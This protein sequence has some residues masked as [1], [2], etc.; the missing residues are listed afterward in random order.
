MSIGPSVNCS[1]VSQPGAR[2]CSS[3][4]ICN[5]RIPDAT[6]PAAARVAIARSANA[7]F[8]GAYDDTLKWADEATRVAERTGDPALIV[9]ARAARLSGVAYAG[10]VDGARELHEQLKPALDEL[11]DAQLE[12]LLDTLRSLS[13]AELYLDLYTDAYAHATRGLAIAR[14]TGHTHLMP[15]FT[16]VAGTAAWMI[17][18]IDAAIEIFDDAIE[19]A[20][21]LDNGSVLAWYLF[22]RAMPELVLGDLDEAIRFTDE[23]WRLAEPL[24][25]GM[26]RGYSAAARAGALQAVGQPAEALELLY[27]CCG[28]PELTLLGG[29]WRGVW[30]EIAV[31]CHLATGDTVA[32]QAAAGRA[33]ALATAMP[34]D[35]AV[36]T[37]DRSEAAHAL[38][39]GDA[40]GAVELLRSAVTHSESM[41]S[42]V[43][44]AWSRELLGHALE[45]AGDPDGAVAELTTA[46]D[47]SDDLGSIRHRDRIDADLRR[48]GRTV[49]RRTR[50]G[51]RGVEGLASLTG[52]ELE[53]AALIRS[54]ATNREIAN[55]LFLSLKTVETHIRN[56]FNKLGV[57]SRGEVARQLA[58]AEPA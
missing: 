27:R 2:C 23:S 6:S 30:F 57:S 38:A 53:V 4:T 44:V 40:G 56:I 34:V 9:A 36:T 1:N 28:G 54:H 37:A 22:N 43:Y 32:A 24:P 15:M 50:P 31:G 14:R 26:I 35:L 29:A 3:S 39:T 58:V 8:L 16:P 12:P 47:M 51:V 5:G 49:H 11:D 42:P 33:R 19:A 18:K 21:A 45:A 41:Q 55:E 20:R 52:R 17:G 13:S 25:E 48:L 10:R 7:F 46:S